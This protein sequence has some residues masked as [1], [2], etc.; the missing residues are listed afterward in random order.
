MVDGEPNDVSCPRPPS[1]INHYPSTIPSL[2]AFICVHLRFQKSF[3]LPQRETE[4]DAALDGGEAE[5]FVEADGVAEGGV[6]VQVG[7]RV[8]AG[9]HV[10]EGGEHQRDAE[11]LAAVLG[12][13][14][15]PVDQPD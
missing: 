3:S 4:E 15:H 7:F 9:L 11:L 1:A 10:A 6:G 5:A 14:G 13:D 12:R 8:A 2:S